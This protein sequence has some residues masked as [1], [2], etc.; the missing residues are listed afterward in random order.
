MSAL[1]NKHGLLNRHVSK[2]NDDVK[3]GL[4]EIQNHH[5][6]EIIEQ[7]LLMANL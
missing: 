3:F 5:W 2:T 7:S 6:F 1:S 4:F